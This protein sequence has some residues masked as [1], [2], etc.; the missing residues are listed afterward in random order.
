VRPFDE[1]RHSVAFSQWRALSDRQPPYLSPEFFALTRPLCDGEAIVAEA[2]E[3]D[4]LIGALPLL[5]RGRSLEALA[6]PHSPGFD[7]V[8]QLC[9]LDAIWGC[10]IHDARWDVMTL[11]R[12]GKASS[13]A[14]EI[15]RLASRD[16]LHGTVKPAAPD[17]YLPLAGFESRMSPKF[18]A[19]VRRCARKGG[20]GTLERLTRPSRADFGEALAIEARAWK[21]TAQTS[22]GSDRGAKH[23]YEVLLRLSSARGRGTLSFLRADGK[24]IALLVSIEDDTSIY[25]LKIGYDPAY[26]AR[27]PG[28][29][30]IWSVAADAERR[31]LSSLNFGGRE[32]AWKHKWTDQRHEHVSLLVY[33]RSPRGI[34][35]HLLRDV[36]KPRL[37]ERMRDLHVP[38]RAAC[39]GEDVLAGRPGLMGRG[40]RSHAGLRQARRALLDPSRLKQT[41]LSF[42][43][44]AIRS[45]A[46]LGTESRFRQGC[47]VRVKDEASIRATLDAT[48]RHRGLALLPAQWHACGNVYRVLKEVRRARDR[49]GVFRSV[50][51]T[52]LLD[53]VTC[54]GPGPPPLGCGRRCPA[55]FRDEWLEPAEAP[56]QLPSAPFVGLRAH[57]REWVDI[58]SGLDL[59]GRRDGVTFL[60]EM[61]QY[62]GKRYRV[63]ARLPEVFESGTWSEPRGTIYIL[64][65]LSCG[66]AGVGACGPCD[67]ACPLLW[68]QDWLILED[69]GGTAPEG[70]REPPTE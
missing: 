63:V 56:R 20:G 11:E 10:L 9:G 40:P 26:A 14:V 32:D 24:R 19:N 6:S 50:S 46:A 44:R 41:L 37:P 42:E 3:G 17:L 38:L 21:G 1:L 31:G 27:S 65:G 29:L 47:W 5:L 60:P 33:R 15:Q 25:A 7:Y 57:V 2:H 59:R 55:F 66:G 23:L 64:E 4:R 48:Q 18:L 45:L 12:L 67:S 28:H 53:G 35:L 69:A 58:R 49:R 13:L 68:H 62:V 51:G 36:I 54:D 61:E 16:G 22:I 34:A 39:Q 70:P 43:A 8:G 52:V 30:L